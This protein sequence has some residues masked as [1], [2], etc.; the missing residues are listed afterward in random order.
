MS[1]NTVVLIT[2][3]SRGIGL[4]LTKSYLFRPNH[5]VIATTRRASESLT[6]LTHDPTSTLIVL[7]L[8]PSS[9]TS[10]STAFATL[11][12]YNV[13]HIDIVLANAGLLSMAVAPV[14][15]VDPAAV[16]EHFNVNT[17]GALHAF[18]S[19]WPFLRKAKAPK[20]VLLGSVLASIGGVEKRPVPLNAY[21][22]GKVGA[23]YLV[24]K[25]HVENEGLV[26]FVVDP[27]RVASEG[28]KE[29]A[30]AFG[31]PEPPVSVQQSVDFIMAEI[32]KSTREQT[33]GRF[34]SI[35][36]KDWEW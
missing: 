22:A 26:A 5:I 10:T 28:G 35:E 32:D 29:A 14:S 24:R 25:I 6:S 34:V 30:K 1:S 9:A 12:S 13:S 20:F 16:L 36:G 31:L 27:G 2:G 15:T 17:L 4:G 7:T 8:D 19:A 21:G 18:Q 11:S 3:A 33:G 23:H